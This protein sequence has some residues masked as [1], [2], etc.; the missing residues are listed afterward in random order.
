MEDIGILEDCLRVGRAQALGC[1]RAPGVGGKVYAL[2]DWAKTKDE[3]RYPYSLMIGQHDIAAIIQ[4][5]LKRYPC[6]RVEF[7]SEVVDL[8]QDE[9]GVIL[10]VKRLGSG[11][12]GR[13]DEIRTSYVVGAD[14]G[15]SV[16]RKAVGESLEG[17]TYEDETFVAANIYFPFE[18]YPDYLTRNFLVGEKNGRWA[19]VARTGAEDAPWRVAYGE[20]SSLSEEEIRSRAKDKISSMMPGP[21]DFEIVQLQPYR[22]HQR[23]ASKYRVGRVLLAGDAAHLNNPIGVG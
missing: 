20:H 12:D 3:N 22:V 16:V 6:A 2:T 21:D 11:A 23:T 1:Y 18:R 9:E 8:K 17:F 19:V 15:K 5:H 14:G 4:T 7:E 10:R 13:I